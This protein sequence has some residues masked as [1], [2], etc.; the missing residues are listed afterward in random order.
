[1]LNMQLLRF[2]VSGNGSKKINNKISFPHKLDMNQFMG[3]IY[4]NEENANYQLFAALFHEGKTA[5]SGHYITLIKRENSWYQ[6]NDQQ[7]TKLKSF[8]VKFKNDEDSD[9]NKE[10]GTKEKKNKDWETSKNAYMLV[11]RR[12]S[13]ADIELPNLVSECNLPDN[14]TEMINTDNIEFQKEKEMETLHQTTVKEIYKCMEVPPEV[15]EFDIIS[16]DWLSIFFAA[17][18]SSDISKVNN[19][20]LLCPH[21]KLDASK[22][23]KIISRKSADEIYEKYDGGPRMLVEDDLCSDC[24]FY[25]LRLDSVR[26]EMKV[27]SKEI[28]RLSKFKNNGSTHY[29]IGKESFKK[30]REMRETSLKETLENNQVIENY[31][32]KIIFIIFHLSWFTLFQTKNSIMTSYVSMVWIRDS[33]SS[34]KIIYH[35][36]YQDN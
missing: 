23:F 1:M 20:R 7:V 24:A 30:W 8:D 15:N 22:P 3:N 4:Q 31:P 11:Y 9:E 10:N 33:W 26:E 2:E 16:K 25:K 27:D 5:N 36:L 12:E 18:V 34:V 29:W 14:L 28:S 35:F 32:S 21:K 19:E 6:F 13:E 17:K